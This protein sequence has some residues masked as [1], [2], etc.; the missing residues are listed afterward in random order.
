MTEIATTYPLVLEILGFTWI[1]ASTIDT[2]VQR[3]R[4]SID[5]VISKLLV[6][7]KGTDAVTLI[8]FVGGLLPKFTP[9]VDYSRPVYGLI[10]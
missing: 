9:E 4:T 10:C 6:V 7:F 2:E 1:N 8:D 3:V 5:S